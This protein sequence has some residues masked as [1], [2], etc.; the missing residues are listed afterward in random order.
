M[1]GNI[2]KKLVPVRV[3]VACVVALLVVSCGGESGGEDTTTTQATGVETTTTPAAPEDSEGDTGDAG[4][5]GDF[6]T[7]CL[8]ATQAM[9]EAASSYS[10]GL[11]EA[12]SGTLDDE[13][14]QA[15]ADQLQAMSDAAPDEIKDDFRMI[16]D[17]LAAF[18][19]AFGEIGYQ[20][21]ATPTPEQAE[22]LAALAE[23]F[24][25]D[26]FDEASQ[27][28]EAWFEGNCQG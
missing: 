19:T 2:M 5:L 11:T 10:T 6:S 17:A 1:W 22:Q 12:F 27:N 25:N 7:V 9:A 15:A 14:L 24:D 13:A 26:A 20:P 3:L 18:Y 21:G 28:I 4:S 23:A 8:E 16:A